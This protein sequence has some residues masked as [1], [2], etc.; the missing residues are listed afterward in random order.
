MA[1]CEIKSVYSGIAWGHIKGINSQ[2]TIVIKNSE[3]TMEEVR[4]VTD[5]AI[6][7]AFPQDREMIHILP[8]K[9]ILDDQDGIRDP[10]GMKGV[11]LEARVHIITGDIASAQNIIKSCNRANLYVEDIVL[12]HLASSE[13]VL[14][15]DEKELGVA[16]VDIGGG[17]TDLAIFIDG[18]I[19][20]TSVLSLAGN[21]MTD[22]IAKRLHITFVEAEKIKQKY[23][24]CLSSMVGK[25]EFFEVP[26]IE[27][28]T[29]FV[30]S[31]LF[32]AEILEQLVQVIFDLVNRE[33]TKSGYGDSLISG[34]VITG[35]SSMLEGIPELAEQVFN[36]PVRRGIPVSIGGIVDAVNSPDF[37]TAVGL[38]IYG[39]KNTKDQPAIS[40]STRGVRI[41][42]LYRNASRTVKDCWQRIF[43]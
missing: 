43:S 38:V 7:I 41:D 34:M 19:I 20:H 16:L 21:K 14:S 2:G 11:R 10:L 12:E 27:R 4:Q 26:G 25:D 5:D 17:T 31:R 9:F 23:G 28:H 8:Q 35:G 30:I 3:V 13:A 37:A 33:I 1:G 22:E 42:N 32:L 29:P 24:C 39:C 6:A 40:K 18:A 15:A 36:L